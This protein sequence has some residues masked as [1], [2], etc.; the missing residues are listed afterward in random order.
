M[1]LRSI[2]IATMVLVRSVAVHGQ[3]DRVATLVERA[4]RY[5]R[6]RTSVVSR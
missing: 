1:R 2:T 6:M 4:G 5:V 3:D